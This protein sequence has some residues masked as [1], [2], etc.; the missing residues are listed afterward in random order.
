MRRLGPFLRAAWTLAAP[1]WS[2]EERWRARLLLGVVVALELSLVAMN[3]VLTY[4]QRAFYNALEARDWDAFIGLLLWWHRGAEG[5]MPGF[6]PIAFAFILVAVYRLYL[7]QALEIRWRRWLTR[8]YL[9][10][11]LDRRAY[12][13]IALTDPATDNPDQRIADD[14]R[15]FIEDGLTLGLGLLNAAVTLV[16]FV[17]VLWSLSGP[18]TLLGIEIPGYLVWV[19]L[20]YATLGSWL[21]HRFGRTLIPLNFERQKVEADFRYALVRLREN[22][23]GVA[24]YGG[25][26]DEKRG[27]LARFQAL[28]EN[29]WRI[30]VTTKRVV[31]FSA[32]YGQ[33][34]VVFPYV[35]AS[36]AYFAGRTTLGG[37]FQTAAAF[38][39]VRT[40]LSWFVDQGNYRQIAEWIATVQRLTSFREAIDA[41][42]AGA[43]AQADTGLHVEP[44]PGPDLALRDVTIALPEGRR[45]IEDACLTVAPADSVLITG[46][47]GSGKS[48]LF[49]AAAGIW[50]F[51][52]GRV[53]VPEGASALFLPQRPYFP[54]GSLRRA[55]CYPRDAAAFT[56]EQIRTALRDAGLP[57][58]VDRLDETD[59]WDR[60]LSGGEQQRLAV[61]R[62]L[63]LRPDFL[64]LDEATAS[65]DPAG[66]ERLYAVL[67]ERLPGTAIVSIAHRPAVARFHDRRLRV[68]DGRLMPA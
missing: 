16:S 7:Q 58:L 24:L 67:K 2:S 3:V 5:W 40:S 8:E 55:V 26:A 1:Y 68:E 64:F 4:W 62:A 59:A 37:L 21:I 11:W 14:I 63:L 33:V 34:A 30:M 29:W 9:D 61:A 28:M 32:S 54:L 10:A 57:H 42:N 20:L 6:T 39:Q 17:L 51:G 12:Y 25:E 13:R 22:A 15:L 43:V 66:E 65:L 23:E 56:D 50:P 48:T 60:R 53:E 35:V 44:T 46:P 18:L 45:L 31:G 49:R 52:S 19:A 41:A 47:S 27:L 36:P 38:D